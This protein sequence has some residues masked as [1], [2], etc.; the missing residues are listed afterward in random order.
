MS[1]LANYTVRQE[2]MKINTS[3]IGQKADI[4]RHFAISPL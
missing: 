1:I 3:L 2:G 4:F